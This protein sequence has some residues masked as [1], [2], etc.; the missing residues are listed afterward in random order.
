MVPFKQARET[1][2]Q[3]KKVNQQL[4]LKTMCWICVSPLTVDLELVILYHVVSVWCR[5][6]QVESYRT[7]MW[8]YCRKSRSHI[9]VCVYQN[10]D[11]NPNDQNANGQNP[12]SLTLNLLHSKVQPQYGRVGQC[13]VVPRSK[14]KFKSYYPLTNLKTACIWVRSSRQRLVPENGGFLTFSR[15]V[16][17]SNLNHQHIIRLITSIFELH[18]A[19]CV[20]FQT[21]NLTNFI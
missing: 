16:M 6:I 18:Q 17:V 1:W 19:H 20:S 9:F 8:M 11:Q 14:P 7:M 4:Q 2:L 10:P 5:A 15:K 12:N 3:P 21:P 13:P